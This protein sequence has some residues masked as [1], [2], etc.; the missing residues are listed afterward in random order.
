MKKIIVFI[1]TFFTL[2]SHAQISRLSKLNFT[3]FTTREQNNINEIKTLIDRKFWSNPD[4]GYYPANAQRKN[5]FIELID[6][7]DAY[8]RFMV[9]KNSKGSH[10]ISQHSFTPL[11]YKDSDG[12]WR[13]INFHLEPTSSLLIFKAQRQRN[14]V[15]IDLLQKNIAIVNGAKSIF[16]VVTGIGRSTVSWK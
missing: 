10:F 2:I 5:D 1:F 16:G 8:N 3:T 13:E 15:T 6:R 14:P 12:Y 7:R 9:E 11:N 4:L